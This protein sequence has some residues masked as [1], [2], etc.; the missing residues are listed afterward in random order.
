M[1][2]KSKAQDKAPA[3][4]IVKQAVETEAPITETGWVSP[5]VAAAMAGEPVVYDMDLTDPAAEPTE[6]AADLPEA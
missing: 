3:K 2:A 6:D 1:A 5:V 4:E